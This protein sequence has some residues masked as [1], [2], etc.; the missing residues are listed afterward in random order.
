VGPEGIEQ[1][2]KP[3][4]AVLS[5][6]ISETPNSEAYIFPLLEGDFSNKIDLKKQ[7]S[8]KNAL[9]N[10][11]LKILARRAKIQA[12]VTFHVARHSFADFA[13]QSDM[14]LYDISKALGHTDIKI[15]EQYLASFDDHSLDK[16]ME[17]LF[18]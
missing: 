5:H 11:N 2:T 18:G 15:T 4:I 9:A 1:L 16:G 12:N 7:I 17:K 13:R 6:Y 10:K 14:N 3:V 8:S